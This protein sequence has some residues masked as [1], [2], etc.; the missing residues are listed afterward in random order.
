MAS[1]GLEDNLL[2]KKLEGEDWATA[3]IRF[4]DGFF[5][6]V[7]SNYITQGGM[8][9]RVEFYCTEGCLHVDLTFS[10][11]I[12]AFSKQ[13]LDYTVEK[14]D[15]TTG[16]SRP[17]VDEKFNLGYTEEIDHFIE[18][19]MAG[20]DARK[21]LRGIDGLEAL[22]VVKLIYK[23]AAEGIRISNPQK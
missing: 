4:E 8:E 16:W 13:G 21:G 9:D 5:A 2:H 1:G 7:E 12:H 19:E 23:S 18:C 15:I 11:P 3:M 22:K 10:S 17:A 20:K 14:S 6:L